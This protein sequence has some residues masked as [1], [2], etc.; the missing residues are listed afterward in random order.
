MIKDRVIHIIDY[1]GIKRE[2]FFE[3]I[4][5]SSANFRGPAKKTPL[6][7]NA[8][9][10]ILSLYPDIDPNWLLT[11]NGEMIR[12]NETVPESLKGPPGAKTEKGIPL[13]PVNA[14]AGAFNIDIPVVGYDC[15]YFD[16]PTFK[17]A[18]FLITVRGDSMTPNYKP[19]D[20]VACKKIQ[21]GSFI[22]WNRV[23]V[24]DTDQ[25]PIIKRVRQAD[26]VD[27]LLIISDNQEFSPFE[28]SV[29]NIHNIA[30]VL[31]SIRPE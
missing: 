13:L 3:K 4:G 18:D 7:S 19:G 8:I 28:I 17:G 16:I 6:N 31:G 24:I 20:I 23:Y 22:Q 2:S 5:M 15:E 10:N 1:K 29:E 9:E 14:E 21:L 25:G 12:V 11:G 26:K 30:L 27:K